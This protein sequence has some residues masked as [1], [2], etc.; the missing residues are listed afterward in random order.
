MS[1]F[2]VVDLVMQGLLLGGLYA[3]FAIGLSLSFGIMRMVNIAHGD[4]IV[5]AAYVALVVVQTLGVNPFFAMMVVVPVLAAFGYVL[6][7]VLLNPVLGD[8]ILPPLLVTFGLSV[9]IQN[10]LLAV[11]SADS[12]GI[13]AGAI[14]T[15]S[16]G[17][18]DGL[19]VGVL[20][21]IIF[22]SA[23]A[24]V[25]GLE[26]LFA[27]TG[28]GRAFRAT[29]DNQTVAQLMGIDNRHLYAIA[30][31]IAFAITAIAGSFLAMRTTFVPTLG[32]SK[33]LV[34]FEAIIVGGMG[35]LWGTL[36]GAVLLGVAQSIGFR[37]DSGSGVLAG[38]LVFLA[39]LLV[40]PQ[41]LFASARHS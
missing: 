9:I 17:F 19:A 15:A 18:G 29:S 23:V 41:G 7:R 27:H 31:A 38:H 25:A 26:L 32:P 22:V 30:T 28:L 1:Y 34:A 13:H 5:L 39:I 24:V 21:L 14:E 12:M 6:Q 35:S 8:D 36:A 2:A 4:I 16:I 33:L 40:R 37:Y 20:P 11:F 10:L 3:L